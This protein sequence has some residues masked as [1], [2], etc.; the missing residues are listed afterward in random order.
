MALHNYIY[1]PE[2]EN[3]QSPLKPGERYQGEL[4][5]CGREVQLVVDSSRET[6]PIG[7]LI[8]P[9]DSPKPDEKL[10]A[11][12]EHVGYELRMLVIA[13]IKQRTIGDRFAYTAWFLHCR[14]LMDFFE[15]KGHDSDDIAAQHFVPGQE[16]SWHKA[17]RAEA[18]PTGYAKWRRHVNKLASHLT[19]DRIK[20]G[21]C[22]PPPSPDVTLYMIRLGVRFL[23]FLPSERV[24]WFA[25]AFLKDG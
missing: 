15:G 7:D 24:A 9:V 13:L 16:H 8:V 12:A 2:N 19:Y 22:S 20:Y 6:V 3:A 4:A 18:T 21:A 11:A 25:H 14:N 5:S 23:A 10:E 1:D 17:R